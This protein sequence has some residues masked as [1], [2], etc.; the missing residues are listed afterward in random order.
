[1]QLHI[2]EVYPYYHIKLFLLKLRLISTSSTP[3]LAFGVNHAFIFLILPEF[4][5][6]CII[7]LEAESTDTSG[8]KRLVV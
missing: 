6:L 3:L 5:I 7:H 2:E 8:M 1:V 4:M